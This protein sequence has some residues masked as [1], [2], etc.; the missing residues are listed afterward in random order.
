MDRAVAID[1]PS[2]TTFPLREIDDG[3]VVV[4]VAV[5]ESAL[6]GTTA[7]FTTRLGGVSRPPYDSLNMGYHV[8]DSPVDVT[9]NRLRVFRA[10]G[11]RAD[12]LVTCAQVH[13]DRVAVVSGSG[14]VAGADGLVTG[15]GGL[16]LAVFCADCVPVWVL[17][18]RAGAVAVVHAG[19]RGTLTRIAARAVEVLRQKFGSRPRDLVAAVGPSIGPCC[20]EVGPEVAEQAAAALG[21]GVILLGAAGTRAHL[22]LREGNRLALLEAG[23]PERGIHV[24]GLCTCCRED[25]FHSH[26]RVVRASG[27]DARS[28]RMAALARLPE[29]A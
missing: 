16:T 2:P 20:Y 12:R 18:P 3:I 8:G 29:R 28:G 13:G 24:A 1:N 6:P 23:V 22:D 7:V 14:S 10:L 26:R 25:L 9:E 4:R 15:V 19:W 17:D 11:L 21:P 5:L 27:P